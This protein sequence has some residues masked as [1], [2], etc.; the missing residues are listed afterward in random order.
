VHLREWTLEQSLGSIANRARRSRRQTGERLPSVPALGENTTMNTNKRTV[1]Y[2]SFG[3]RCYAAVIEVPEPSDPAGGP[4]SVPPGF[5]CIHKVQLWQISNAPMVES[6][7]I[8]D[9]KPTKE[10]LPISETLWFSLHDRKVNAHVRARNS[11][12]PGYT[13]CP[14]ITLSLMPRIMPLSLIPPWRLFIREIKIA[15]ESTIVAQY[16]RIYLPNLRSR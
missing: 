16:G 15:A 8:R 3:V 7:I 2:K 5:I 11:F 6:G 9:K 4:R 14:Q 10:P 12:F 1:N 13:S